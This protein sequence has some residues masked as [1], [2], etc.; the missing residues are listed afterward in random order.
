MTHLPCEG[1]LDSRALDEG[2]FVPGQILGER[3][4]IVAL[5]GRRPPQLHGD[6]PKEAAEYHFG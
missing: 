2:R 6:A 1:F 3:Y 4:R 5:L